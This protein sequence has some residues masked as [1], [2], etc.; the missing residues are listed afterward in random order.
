M[1]EIIYQRKTD[2]ALRWQDTTDGIR[3]LHR[4]GTRRVQDVLYDLAGRTFF[5]AQN[6]GQ[7]GV[8]T[9]GEAEYWG[10]VKDVAEAQIAELGGKDA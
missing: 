5:H 2:E 8:V 3:A 7:L 9:F 10:I 4:R 1:A 6:E